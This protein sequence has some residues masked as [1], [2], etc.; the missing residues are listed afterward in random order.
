VVLVRGK[1][2][3][4]GNAQR[5]GRVTA[6]RGIVFQSDGRSTVG[7]LFIRPFEAI[8]R[9]MVGI[10]PR[11]GEQSLAMHAGIHIEID[12][13]GDYV[14]EQLVGTWYL[15]LRDGLNWT[16]YRD[17]ARRDRG[18]WD[19]TVPSTSFRQVDEDVVHA[20]LDGL[21]RIEGQPF[22]GEDC[23]AFIE[24]AFGYRRLFADSPLLRWFGIGVRIGDPALPLL[25][26][27]AQLEPR[28]R[29]WLQFETIKHVP[30]AIADV[31]SPN[32]LL[33]AHRLLPLMLLTSAAM[34][35]YSSASRR[36]TPISSTARKFFR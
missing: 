13:A 32:A 20:T 24:R 7:R 3:V 21:N 34:R 30:D 8:D 1:Y 36:S 6:I 4:E 26:P 5:P 22:F 35:A 14:V 19:V 9:L 18:G 23:T 25:R 31:G 17:F 2:Y 33:L 10:L 28:T 29:E 12:G 27:D 11:P 15:D 16:P